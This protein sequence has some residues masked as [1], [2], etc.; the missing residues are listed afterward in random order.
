MIDYKALVGRIK[1]HA[2]LHY[3]TDDLRTL[4]ALLEGMVQAEPFAWAVRDT[5]PL[6][7]EPG[8]WNIFYQTDEPYIAWTHHEKVPLYVH[9]APQPQPAQ[10]PEGWRLVP[11]E[12]TEEMVDAGCDVDARAE[13]VKKFAAKSGVLDPESWVSAGEVLAVQYRAMLAA[14]P[15]YQP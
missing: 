2:E 13:V 8:P 4:V 14:S 7:P 5:N 15:E 11:V 10:P 6:F 1:E 9:P 3:W 12:P